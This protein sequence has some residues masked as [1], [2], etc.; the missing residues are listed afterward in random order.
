MILSVSFIDIHVWT[1][2]FSLMII[3]K[4]LSISCHQKIKRFI[5]QEILTLTYSMLEPTPTRLSFFDTMMSNF[6]LP[7]ITIPTKINM[8]R[9]GGAV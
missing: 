8:M 3:L 1:L 2:P 5:S 7:V 4:E 6:L 9:I